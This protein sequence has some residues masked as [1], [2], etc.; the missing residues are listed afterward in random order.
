MMRV[1][2]RRWLAQT[3]EYKRHPPDAPALTVKLAVSDNGNK[4]VAKELRHMADALGED[5]KH[6]R[7]EFPDIGVDNDRA[8]PVKA[9]LLSN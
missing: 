8:L 1:A 3:A 7:L 4:R 2:I 6:S 9:G 5:G